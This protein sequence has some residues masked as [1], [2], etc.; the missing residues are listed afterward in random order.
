MSSTRMVDGF[1]EIKQQNKVCSDC[2]MSKKRKSFPSQ[3]NYV[4]EKVLEVV[5]SDLCSLIFPSISAGNMY[6]FLMVDDYS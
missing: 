2:L 5:H 1:P 4:A 6:F 3:S